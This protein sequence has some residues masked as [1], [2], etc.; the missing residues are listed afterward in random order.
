MLDGLPSALETAAS[1]LALYRPE[2][3]LNFLRD[4]SHALIEFHTK[5]NVNL[6]AT[7]RANL[8]T[9]SA[10]DL[11]TVRKLAENES[12]WTI[13]GLALLDG[14]SLVGFAHQVHTLCNLGLIRPVERADDGTPRFTVLKA[15]GRLLFER[16]QAPVP[17]VT[18]SPQFD[19]RNLD[20]ARPI[21]VRDVSW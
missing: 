18:R 19:R 15:V 2:S 14:K 16:T 1:W 11:A 7:I 13:E 20:F 4:S 12:S 9:L 21:P 17:L 3:L 10:T 8:S 5:T 6:C